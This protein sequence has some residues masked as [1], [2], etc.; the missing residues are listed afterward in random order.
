MISILEQFDILLQ[1][2]KIEL[3]FRLEEQGPIS[4]VSFKPCGLFLQSKNGLLCCTRARVELG[5]LIWMSIKLSFVLN[6]CV[7]QLL[8]VI[9]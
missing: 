9:G 7:F 2:L 1:V 8:A 3:L 6:L 5:N 4:L